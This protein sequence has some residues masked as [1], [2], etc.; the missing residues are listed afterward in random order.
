M[1]HSIH[2]GYIINST[3]G[4]ENKR[5]SMPQRDTEVFPRELVLGG[6]RR[7]KKGFVTYLSSNDPDQSIHVQFDHA[8]QMLIIKALTKDNEC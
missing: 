6:L 5:S 3:N 2:H 1:Y 8:L 7:V 4:S